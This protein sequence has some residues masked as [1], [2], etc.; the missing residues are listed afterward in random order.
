MIHYKDVQKNFNYDA[1]FQILEINLFGVQGVCG[2]ILLF[3]QAREMYEYASKALKLIELHFNAHW[4]IHSLIH[5]QV[6]FFSTAA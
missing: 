6:S 3:E 2:Y 1:N 4:F 5:L